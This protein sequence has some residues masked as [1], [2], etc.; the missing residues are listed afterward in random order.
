[1]VL[2]VLYPHAVEIGVD[3]PG[4]VTSHAATCAG[5]RSGLPRGIAFAKCR[6]KALE[7]HDTDARQGSGVYVR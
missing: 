2:D 6:T 7:L 4:V 3:C 1:M 5:L